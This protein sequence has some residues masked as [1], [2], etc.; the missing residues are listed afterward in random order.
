[1]SGGQGGGYHFENCL[2][3]LMNFERPTTCRYHMPFVVVDVVGYVEE[4]VMY[5]SLAKAST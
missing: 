3:L 5:S 4:L 1:M 2:T